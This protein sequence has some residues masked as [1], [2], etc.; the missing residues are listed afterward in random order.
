MKKRLAGPTRFAISGLFFSLTFGLLPACSQSAKDAPIPQKNDAGPV[1][2]KKVPD[3]VF[4]EPQFFGASLKP[5]VPRQLDQLAPQLLGALAHKPDCNPN[6][7]PQMPQQ[8]TGG[9][10][11]DAGVAAAPQKA[12]HSIR[13]FCEKPSQ[14][15]ERPNASALTWDA[16]HNAVLTP[17][18]HQEAPEV[19]IWHQKTAHL[20]KKG[21]FRLSLQRADGSLMPA[22]TWVSFSNTK[23]EFL[24]FLLPTGGLKN[25]T[26]TVRLTWSA[27]DKNQEKTTRTEIQLK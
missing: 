1:A 12:P 22:Q 4:F 8:P 10:A 14:T 25:E 6:G 9:A 18:A 16:A 26:G 11:A 17:W 15:S 23:Q 2:I 13:L 3:P 27:G 19:L 24:G 21:K 5:G 7:K 20:P